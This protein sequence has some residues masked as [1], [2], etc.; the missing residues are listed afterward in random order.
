M[1]LMLMVNH[2]EIF[3]LT[4]KKFLTAPEMAVT[5]SRIELELIWLPEY[6]F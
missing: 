1:S 2:T 4:L 3:S 6:N 5:P